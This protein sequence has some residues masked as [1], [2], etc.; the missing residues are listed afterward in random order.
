[1]I[2]IVREPVTQALGNVG[3]RLNFEIQR[4]GRPAGSADLG[5]CAKNEQRKKKKPDGRGFQRS[6]HTDLSQIAERRAG[7]NMT[8]ATET[9]NRTKVRVPGLG[10][11]NFQRFQK[12]V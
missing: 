8:C 4:F 12:E 9:D 3:R 5:G 10:I 7:N 1:M 11:L 6:K 2:R